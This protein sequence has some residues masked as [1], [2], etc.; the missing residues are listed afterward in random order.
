MV[1]ALRSSAMGQGWGALGAGG[2]PGPA[3]RSVP[4]PPRPCC[5]QPFRAPPD[6]TVLLIPVQKSEAKR[7]TA[8]QMGTRPGSGLMDL[9]K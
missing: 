9:Y 6:P 8:A 2:L 3:P 1:R 7:D 5:L 4:Q